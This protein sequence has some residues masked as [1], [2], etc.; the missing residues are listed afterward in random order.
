FV[1]YNNFRKGWI[2]ERVAA[3]AEQVFGC[4]PI[5]LSL[6]SRDMLR[7]SDWAGFTMI[8]T[9]CSKRIAED[10]A[11]HPS[12]WLSDVSQKK[13]GVDG[14]PLESESPPVDQPHMWPAIAP[15]TLVHDAGGV[16]FATDD[17]P[18]LYLRGRLI[19][20]LTLRSVILMGAIGLIMV[21]LFLPRG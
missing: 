15:T 7:P 9:T 18:F 2:V 19:P 17:W 3:M 13:L 8:I 6:P 20:E 12:L 16:T 11:A 21:F 5:V 4:K 1:T 14:F 10:F